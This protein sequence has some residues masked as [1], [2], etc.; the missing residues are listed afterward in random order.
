[1]IIRY[2]LVSHTNFAMMNEFWEKRY[3][4]E[5]YVYGKEP[6][7]FFRECLDGLMPGKILLP[8][9]GEGRNA[10]YAAG[11]GW[12]VYAFDQSAAGRKKAMRLASELG[13]QI[14]YE[15]GS[16]FD[17]PYRKGF[18]DLAALIFMHIHPKARRMFHKYIMNSLCP[19]GL[20]VMEAFSKDQIRNA[21]GGPHDPDLLY[22]T[23]DIM[24]D[25]EGMEVIKATREQIQLNEGPSHQGEA[26][27]VRFFAK[28][29]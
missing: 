7:A 29:I 17:I 21:S 15:L 1:M 12:D 18:Y 13:V 5:A 6:N 3:S 11:L 27:V 24:E 16:V 26:N 19:G 20:L 4:Q 2:Y 28:K 23:D 14:D 8:G 10:V 9:E 25:F 22:M